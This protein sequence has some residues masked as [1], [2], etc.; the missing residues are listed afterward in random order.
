VGALADATLRTGFGAT[1][2]GHDG[3][4]TTKTGTP[5]PR[6]PDQIAPMLATL[7]TLEA[8]EGDSCWTYEMK[9]DGVRALVHVDGD[10]IRLI[11]RNGR[12][13]S[14]A[15]PEIAPVADVPY[16]SAVL[17]GEIV[18]FDD[19]GRPSFR[20][21]QKR[22]HMS[23]A[24]VA[25]RLARSD[26]AVLLL[27]DLLSLDGELLLDQPYTERRRRL[28]GLELPVPAWQ[29]PA[30]FAGLGTDALAFSQEHGLEGVVAKRLSSTYQPGRRSPAW[31]KIK[32]VRAQE[33]VIGG[34]TPGKGRRARTIGALLLGVPGSDGLDYAGKVGT[35]F[36]DA[37]LDH[38]AADVESLAVPSSPF[39]SVPRPE[40]R[41]A[42]WVTP[43]LVGE[44]VFSEWTDD[45]RLRH[46][47]WRGLRPDKRPGEVIRES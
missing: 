2:S 28:E 17:D 31:V 25:R 34:W 12:D 9:W 21:L 45:G 6:L 26:P 24:T 43:C 7:G 22:M 20:R 16:R 35:G 1:R 4:M 42:Q 29:T 38:L 41:D 33:V 3:G 27:F 14:V 5:G 13:M 47:A 39:R 19:R 44:V 32:N 36:T 30:A 23:D 18:A 10:Q 8:L 37:M 15:Y 40:A 46:P 11:S